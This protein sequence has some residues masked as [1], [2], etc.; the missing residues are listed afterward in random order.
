MSA[1]L[2][3]LRETPRH[4]LVCE[5]SHVRHERSRHAA[6][7]RGHAYNCRVSFL[8]PECGVLPEPLKSVTTDMGEYY[9][10]KNLPLHELVAQEFISAFVKTG[11][12]Y[13]LSY[14]TRI[15]QDNTAALLP[16][17]KLILS[18]D[19]DTYEEL[20]LQGRPSRYS[21]KKIMRYIITIDL[22]DSAFHSDS[23]K[24]KRVLWAL[25]D[26]K[27]LEFDFL[28]SWH[29]TGADGSTLMSY[30]S[31]HQIQ[32]HQPKITFSTLRNLQCPVLCSNELQGKPEESC[33]AQELFEW[34]GAVFSNVELDNKSFSFVSTYCCPEPSTMMDQAYLCTITGFILPEKIIQLL[35]QLC[36]YFDD[37]KLA[38]WV[39]L[40]VHGFADSPVS[41]RE[42]EHGFQKGGENLY[43][44]VVFRSLDYWLQMA[45]GAN[46]DCPP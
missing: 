16:T 43:N 33:S 13:A 2:R 41:W 38:Q 46:D 23:K 42:N 11:S 4:L 17:G 14:N 10:V 35:D 31:K 26:K 30:F 44:F 37:P 24:Y 20:G 9:L 39:T 19:K 5:R 36:A 45:V 32:A 6:R 3:R 34:L 27:P 7:V 22:T 15:D 28:L 25:R 1:P 12:C 8:I 40:T 29:H 21:G 18:V